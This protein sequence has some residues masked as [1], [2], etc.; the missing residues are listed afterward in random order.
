MLLWHNN[1]HQL[2]IAIGYA[3]FQV[4]CNSEV[5]QT[6]LDISEDGFRESQNCRD[7][8]GPLEIIKSNPL[9]STLPTVVFKYPCLQNRSQNGSLHISLA[10]YLHLGITHQSTTLFISLVTARSCQSVPSALSIT[11]C[12]SSSYI[13]VADTSLLTTKDKKPVLG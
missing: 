7:W 1:S 9:Q 6:H 2:V 3:S 13:P 4:F 11:K 8:K 12:K 5:K 10:Y